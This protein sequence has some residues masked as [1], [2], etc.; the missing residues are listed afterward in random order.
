MMLLPPP[1]PPPLPQKCVPINVLINVYGIGK[2]QHQYGQYLKARLERHFG[3]SICFITVEY[4]EVQIVISTE[5][6]HE[7]TLSSYIEFSENCILV[8]VV[9]TIRNS[10][11]EMIKKASQLSWPPSVDELKSKSRKPPAE[12]TAFLSKLLIDDSH[13]SIGSTKS[14]V[15]RSIADDI[16]YNI[17]N[18]GFLSA[19]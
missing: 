7:E 2:D 11:D 5:C 9:R 15:V 18:G 6:I 12:L 8:L 4:H 19:K 16:I 3:E 10:V 17:S 1:I 14:R 13:H